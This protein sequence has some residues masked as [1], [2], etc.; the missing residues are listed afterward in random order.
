MKKKFV[1]SMMAAFLLLGTMVPALA[2]AAEDVIQP[3][4]SIIVQN[5][6][7]STGFNLSGKTFDV[8]QIFVAEINE[9]GDSIAYEVNSY[10]VEFFEA[11]GCQDAEQAEDYIHAIFD[12]EAT[13]SATDL[14][15]ELRE[16]AVNNATAVSEISGSVKLSGSTEQMTSDLLS[17]GYYLVVDSSS[18]EVT[19]ISSGMLVQLPATDSNGCY[20]SNATITLKGSNPEISKEIWH[21]D[22]TTSAGSFGDWDSAGDYEIGDTVQFK[23]HATIPAD[24]T[25]YETYVYTITDVMS[26]G[27]EFDAESLK[28]YI[29]E[30]LT[31]EASGNFHNLTTDCGDEETFIIEFDMLSI[32]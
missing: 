31:L 18:N 1:A 27:I 19:T 3:Q 8:Y 30:A 11:A 24:M 21:N 20:T 22:L 25:G 23:I 2:V 17:P 9:E 10:F 29:D 15:A 14:V 6:P 16:Y 5:T 28:I 12:G 13:M 4:A 7:S 26:D 32:K